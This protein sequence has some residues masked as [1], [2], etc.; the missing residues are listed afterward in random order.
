[1]VGELAKT[2]GDVAAH[3]GAELARRLR[4][5]TAGDRAELVFLVP[6]EIV[7]EWKQ[8]TGD[9][10]LIVAP[11]PESE[12]PLARLFLELAQALAAAF[13]R[14]RVS[15]MN[16]GLFAAGIPVEEQREHRSGALEDFVRFNSDA[17]VPPADGSPVRQ[18]MAQATSATLLLNCAEATLKEKFQTGED[19]FGFGGVLDLLVEIYRTLAPL[20]ESDMFR[21][22][23]PE[24]RAM[25]ERIA[26]ENTVFVRWN[27]IR[28]LALIEGVE[29][30]TL[31]ELP[32]IEKYG[33]EILAE[34][35]PPLERLR[36][37]FGLRKGGLKLPVL[38]DM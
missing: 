22:D 20:L 32:E 16:W 21:D 19:A 12:V 23:I 38:G 29:M 8:R 3:V 6:G 34:I 2:V 30:G 13:F 37:W 4:A 25:L 10:R 14:Q 5:R 7:N 18:V 36:V 28:A 26:G 1:M 9:Q 31:Q 17:P 15:R 35:T 33:K 11:N 24:Q 27:I